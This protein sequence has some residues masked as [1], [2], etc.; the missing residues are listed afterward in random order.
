MSA[1]THAGMHTADHMFIAWSWPLT[2]W[3]QNTWDYR[4]HCGRNISV[5]WL[6]ILFPSVFFRYCA[7]KQTHCRG[8]VCW[9]SRRRKYRVGQSF[10]VSLKST[11]QNYIMSRATNCF[12]I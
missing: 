9:A 4:T 2:F 5:S 12:T 1:K 6:M 8:C 3:S 7:E 10:F 11:R